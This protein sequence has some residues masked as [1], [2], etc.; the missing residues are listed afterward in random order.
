MEGYIVSYNGDRYI[1]NIH[2][3]NI[4]YGGYLYSVIFGRYVNGG[5]CSIPN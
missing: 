5:F 2:H 3:I 4:E 1:S